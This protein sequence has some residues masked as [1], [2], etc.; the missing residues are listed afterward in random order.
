MFSSIA[1]NDIEVDP[2]NRIKDCRTSF[3]DEVITEGN[4]KQLYFL[5]QA[6]TLLF[7]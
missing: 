3:Q 7:A 2:D 1:S 4:Y 6:D 5:A